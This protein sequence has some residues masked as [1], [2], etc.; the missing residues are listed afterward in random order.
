MVVYEVTGDGS[1]SLTLRNASG[2]TD[3]L[4]VP[5]PWSQTLPLPPNGFVYLSA[6]QEGS[7]TVACK[8]TYGGR[9]VQQASSNGDYVIAT[10]SNPT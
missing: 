7:G 8:I 9:V 4:T 6:Q 5:L 10:C 1:A 3:Q 2:G